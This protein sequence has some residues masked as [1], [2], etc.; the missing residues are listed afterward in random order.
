[1]TADRLSA[2][3]AVLI[4]AAGAADISCTGAEPIRFAE[5]D[6]WR[7]PG[8]IVARIS[9]AGQ[10]K[11][12][13]REVAVTRWLAGSGL[14]AVRPLDIDQ[15]VVVGGRAVTFWEEL[16]PH[17]TGTVMDL[18]P[19]LRQMHDLPV[20]NIPL[21]TMNPFVRVADRITQASWLPDTD[22]TWLMG[23]LADLEQ[24][25]NEL[26]EGRP[27]RVIHGDAWQ[28][29][30]VITDT[31]ATTYLLDFERTSLGRP[32]WDLTATAGDMETFGTLPREDY[33]RYCEAYGHDV[34]SWSGYR[35]MLSIRELRQASFAVQYADEQ[36]GAR[37]QAAYRVS[38]IR[39][40]E[41][42]RPWRWTAIP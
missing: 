21:G 6:I 30:C 42:P 7:L 29:N 35:T 2:S 31:E 13:V 40:L 5:N 28:G 26:P 11:A 3:F 37:D 38:C 39:G 22:R 18:A 36:P 1:M 25:W 17:R 9:R 24:Q 34:T 33:E 19:L 12:A 32:E 15:P 16:P 27:A 4:E 14:R 8:K 20:P 41:G 10:D 23:Q